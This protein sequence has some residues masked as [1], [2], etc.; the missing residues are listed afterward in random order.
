MKL[1]FALVFA[2]F[3]LAM[4]AH[5]TEIKI[6][7]QAL[8]RTL[9]QQLF[10]GPDGK[11]F[12]KGKDGQPCFVYARDP[13]VSFKDDRIVIH[14][15]TKSRLGSSVFGNCIGVGLTTDADVSVI[16]EAEGES[17]GFRDARVDNLAASRELN[18][19]LV[20]FLTKKLPQQMKINAADLIR[21]LLKNSLQ[22]TGYEMHLDGLKI[23]SM[24]VSNGNLV[25]D[26]D[27]E[28]SVK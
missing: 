2:A 15:S 13:K 7:A 18:F 26:F 6:S 4:Q 12:I 1:R 22:Q 23:H 9:H 3:L 5:A 25:V 11:Y 14:V 21:Q 20:P 28:L 24:Q 8:E 17:I 19:L 27:S 10:T 16:P